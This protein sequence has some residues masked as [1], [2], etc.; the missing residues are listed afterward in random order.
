MNTDQNQELTQQLHAALTDGATAIVVYRKGTGLLSG[1]NTEDSQRRRI[2]C[3]L[4]RLDTWLS[5]HFANFLPNIYFYE[6]I[7]S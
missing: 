3:W 5:Q 6:E 2:P 1:L 4:G 7:L